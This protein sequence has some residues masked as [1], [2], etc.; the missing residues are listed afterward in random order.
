M[1]KMLGG[2]LTILL[3]LAGGWSLGQAAAA[4]DVVG[5]FRWRVALA[6]GQENAKAARPGSAFRDCA[7]GC[8]VMIVIPAG[9]FMM[10]S[11]EQELDRDDSEGLQHEVTD[12]KPFAVSKFEVTFDEW[13]ACRCRDSV[14]P[15]RRRLGTRGDARDPREQGRCQA[16]GGLAFTTYRQG[17]S[18]A[19]RGRMGICGTGRHEDQIFLGR[20]S[21]HG[22]W[23]L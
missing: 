16:I 12:A 1:H 23:Q 17:I 8:P 9:R 7:H 15:S 20:R 14:S 21:T 3:S 6:N 11:P 2:P 22:R 18:A 13:D 5:A 4:D 19:H 10:G